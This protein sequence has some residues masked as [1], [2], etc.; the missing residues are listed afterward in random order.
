MSICRRLFVTSSAVVLAANAFGACEA[1]RPQ[2]GLVSTGYNTVQIAT[3]DF[4]HDGIPDFASANFGSNTISVDLGGSNY[5][6]SPKPADHTYTT[7]PNPS[8][9]AAVDY[10]GDGNLDLAV[11]FQADTTILIFLGDGR[12]N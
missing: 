7:L 11:G 5:P 10:N 4:D 1:G 6:G 9:I 2:A 8:A 12:G 3:G